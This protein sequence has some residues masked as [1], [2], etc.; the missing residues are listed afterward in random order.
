MIFRFHIKLD[1][2]IAK[3][4]ISKLELDG[5][6]FSVLGLKMFSHCNIVENIIRKQIRRATQNT[7][8]LNDAMLLR[9]LEHMIKMR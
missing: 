5:C 2:T 3:L 7:I 4:D 1:G 9:E 8:P 6:E